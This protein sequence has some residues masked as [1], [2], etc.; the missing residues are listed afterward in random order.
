[1]Q[2]R[3]RSID[4]SQPSFTR[5]LSKRL[6]QSMDRGLASQ[7]MPNDATPGSVQSAAFNHFN[8]MKPHMSISNLQQQQQQ[9]QQ[10]QNQQQSNLNYDLRELSQED[11]DGADYDVNDNNARQI[12]M[13]TNP[14]ISPRRSQQQQDGAATIATSSGGGSG[15]FR[16]GAV[17][18]Q[19][20]TNPNFSNRSTAFNQSQFNPNNNN[21]NSNNNVRRI[22]FENV[23]QQQQD[24]D[25]LDEYYTVSVY[26]Y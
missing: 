19:P 18:L 12:I 17:N 14:V 9:Q 15:G 5:S 24:F 7:T 16:T 6:T 25:Q 20:K 4:R 26:F 3:N 10:H 23:N 1:M 11:L 2:S 21:I 13:N 8:R 22:P